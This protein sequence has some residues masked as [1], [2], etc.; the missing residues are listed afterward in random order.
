MASAV[1]VYAESLTPQATEWLAGRGIDPDVAARF[2]L[3]VVETPAQGHEAYVGRLSIPYQTPAGPVGINF[4]ALHGEEPK[5]LKPAGSKN[6]LFNVNALH[7]GGGTL[8]ICEGEID[9][10]T[11]DSLGIP[12]VGVSGA[13][14]WLPHYPRIL[15]GYETIL[16]FADNDVKE[17]GRNPGREL[18]TRI[19]DD[20]EQAIYL[21]LPPG[22]DVNSTLIKYG[23]DHLISLYT[24]STVRDMPT[25][26]DI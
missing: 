2:Q 6:H 25:E 14:A 12:A 5:Y 20:L 10:I 24:G 13:Q 23:E 1:K 19:I 22:E 7:R 11:L 16:I 21:H 9:T 18:A 26:G 8:A 15:E 3:G 4:R 17:D